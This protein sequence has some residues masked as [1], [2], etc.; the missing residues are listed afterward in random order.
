MFRIHR[1]QQKCA[2]KS[3]LNI[4]VVKIT[5]GGGVAAPIGSQIFGEVLPYLEVVKD[6]EQDDQIIE[7]ELPNVE[8]KTLKE[9]E[10]ILKENNLQIVIT[11]EQEGMDKENTIVKEQTPKVGIKV[12]EGSSVYVDW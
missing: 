11:N 12:K 1:E 9:A 10:S 5:Q 8:G 7:V 3:S 4:C 6:G 2:S